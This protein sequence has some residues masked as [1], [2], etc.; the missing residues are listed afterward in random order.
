MVPM[1]KV[2]ALQLVF[3][4][5]NA[6]ITRREL[7]VV[8][9]AFKMFD[10]KAR[11]DLN[12]FK[13]SFGEPLSLTKNRTRSDFEEGLQL[14]STIRASSLDSYKRS[15]LGRVPSIFKK[16]PAELR[17]E[18]NMTSWTK[19]KKRAKQFLTGKLK[20][21]KPNLKACRMSMNWNAMHKEMKKKGISITNNQNLHQVQLIGMGYTKRW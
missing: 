4:K 21:V 17:K 3:A 1:S 14:K 16:L 11:G 15:F 6:S 9:M 18:G 8:S 10:G 12:L 5:Q 7:A 19:V 2:H 13:P 20:E